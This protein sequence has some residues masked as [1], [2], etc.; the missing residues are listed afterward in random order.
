MLLGKLKAVIEM[1]QCVLRCTC[2][3]VIYMEPSHFI[4]N[5]THCSKLLAQKC[6]PLQTQLSSE[7]NLRIFLWQKKV[8][9]S[10]AF[11]V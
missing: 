1:W 2:I 11:I 4:V 10:T 5:G 9:F 8:F 6:L 3:Y 7:C